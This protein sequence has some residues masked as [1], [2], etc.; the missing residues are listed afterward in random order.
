MN[1]TFFDTWIENIVYLTQVAM[2][3]IETMN[4]LLKIIDESS[5]NNKNI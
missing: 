4:E 3:R 1:S 5:L 2:S